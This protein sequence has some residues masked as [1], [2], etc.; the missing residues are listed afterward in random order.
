MGGHPNEVLDSLRRA[1]KTSNSPVFF[2]TCSLL[3]I[4]PA[5]VGGRRLS[6]QILCKI[7]PKGT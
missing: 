7:S 6:N 5:T 1:S 4:E 2:C 3:N